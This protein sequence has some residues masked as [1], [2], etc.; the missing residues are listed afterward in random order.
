MSIV[1]FLTVD[2]I[3]LL[4]NVKVT[5]SQ[6]DAADLQRHSRTIRPRLLECG[7]IENVELLTSHGHFENNLGNDWSRFVRF[8]EIRICV[9]A[10]LVYSLCKKIII[11]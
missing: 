3:Y 9:N 7:F 6:E 8:R 10:E 5:F 2:V 11:G 4:P 1:D